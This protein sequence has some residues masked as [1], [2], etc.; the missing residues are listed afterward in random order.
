MNTFPETEPAGNICSLIK[1][2]MPLF[3][4]FREVYLFGSVLDAK[5]NA[6]TDVD[7]LLIY[8]TIS[9]NILE[10]VKEIRS[11]LEPQ[12]GLPIDLTVLSVTEEQDIRFLDRLKFSYFKIK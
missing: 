9:V 4:D 6:P 10:S 3:D 11:T 5:N 12:C 8:T 2:Q 1:Q 7:L